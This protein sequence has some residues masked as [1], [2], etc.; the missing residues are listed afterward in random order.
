MVD[1]SIGGKT[2]INTKH[3]KNLIGT[4]YQPA[5]VFADMDFL[6]TLSD[7]EFRNGLAEVIKISII[8]DKAMFEVTGEKQQKILARDKSTMQK[9]IKETLN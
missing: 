5:A 4:T 3:G 6:E 2:G 8:M 1:S 9:L 7:E